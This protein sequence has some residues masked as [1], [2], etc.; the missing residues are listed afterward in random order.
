MKFIHCKS[1]IFALSIGMHKKILW[2][3]VCVVNTG[4]TTHVQQ[5]E[6]VVALTS[7]FEFE[8]RSITSHCI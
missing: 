4:T 6:V 5:S 8:S 3:D 2:P 1:C 7:F